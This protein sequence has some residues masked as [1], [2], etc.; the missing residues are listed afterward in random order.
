MRLAMLI[1]SLRCGGAEGVAAKLANYWAE[2][3]HQIRY[4]TL[5]AADAETFYTLDPR[6]ERLALDCLASSGNPARA[7]FCNLRR[8]KLVRDAVAAWR[9][10]MLLSFMDTTN[11]CAVLAM[12]GTGIPVVISEHSV[13]FLKRQS[14][15]WKMLINCVYP[16]AAELVVRS[17]GVQHYFSSRKIPSTC[18]PNAVAAPPPLPAGAGLRSGRRIIAAG[19]LSPEK[20]FDLLL[21]SF[22]KVHAL[23][24]DVTLTIFGE[25]PLR[26]ELTRQA[27]SLGLASCAAFPGNTKELSREMAASDLFVMSSRHESFG[28]VLCEA[29]AVGVPVVSFD[30]PT[31]PRDI[32]RHSVDGYLVPPGDTTAL[33]EAIVSLLDDNARRAAMSVRAREVLERFSFEKI[34]ARWEEV[35]MR[36]AG[37]RN[38]N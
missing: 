6:I 3:Q 34:T 31:G 1:S 35:L 12:R 7:V 26:E 22:A 4:I 33:A 21:E 17:A 2:R 18:I 15:L 27:A 30:C 11:V 20:G 36:A 16:H 38:A 28:N 24:P 5:C 14:R 10:D 37:M 25:G 8:I 32:I 19:R 9:P 23:R 13:P 29:L